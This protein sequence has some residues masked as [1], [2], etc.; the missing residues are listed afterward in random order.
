MLLPDAESAEK[1]FAS[2]ASARRH[3]FVALIISQAGGMD[4]ALQPFA[5]QEFSTHVQFM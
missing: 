2:S 3:A 1:D 5:K 4:D